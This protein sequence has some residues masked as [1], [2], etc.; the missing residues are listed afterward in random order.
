MKVILYTMLWKCIIGDSGFLWLLR[1]VIIEWISIQYFAY[2]LEIWPFKRQP[3][4]M[5][6]KHLNNLSATA[7]ELCECVWTFCGVGTWRVN[8][9]ITERIP[10]HTWIMV[11][12]RLKLGT[13]WFLKGNITVL[14][15]QNC[16]TM[17]VRFPSG[18]HGVLSLSL[19]ITM[20]NI[21]WWRLEQTLNSQ[22]SWKSKAYGSHYS[23]PKS[24]NNPPTHR[25]I[26]TCK[27]HLPVIILSGESN[28]KQLESPKWMICCV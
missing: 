16:I 10:V 21:N 18:N 1:H 25:N 6:E 23:R 28:L 8:L 13:L 7:D 17:A 15:V 22:T 4:K 20:N 14:V 9:A 11:L 19:I 27:I 5:V 3:Y 12:M 24:D 2:V 26:Q